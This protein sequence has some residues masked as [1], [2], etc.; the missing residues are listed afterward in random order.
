LVVSVLSV[1]IGEDKP[2]RRGCRTGRIAERLPREETANA[3]RRA[4][5]RVD[6]AA[7][8]DRRHGIYSRDGSSTEI[9]ETDLKPK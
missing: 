6:R 3:G 4:S 5:E 9:S 1:L 7:R 2:Q 8:H